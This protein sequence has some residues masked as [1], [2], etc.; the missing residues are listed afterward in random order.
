MAD[1]SLIAKDALRSTVAVPSRGRKQ[2]LEEEEYIGMLEEV[3]ERQYFPHLAKMK[4]QL[5]FLQESE[6]F[7]LHTLRAAYNQLVARDIEEELEESRQ[8]TLT[9]QEFFNRFTSEDNESFK[10]IFAKDVAD[11]RRKLHWLYESL[12]HLAITDGRQATSN[13]KAGMLMLYHIGNKVLTSE[14]RARVD[15]ILDGERV[16]G[17]DRPSQIDTWAFRVRNQ[18][19]FY[20]DLTDS[21]QIS[22]VV[23]SNP[24]NVAGNSL[25][26]ASTASAVST[27][28]GSDVRVRSALPEQAITGRGLLS[29]T[30]V[31]HGDEKKGDFA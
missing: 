2:V 12:D 18:L 25:L 31:A 21:L 29:L 28:S 14:E 9:V 1:R 27:D 5:E 20:P 11:R 24:G 15:A 26:L 22:G 6:R 17:D 23:S 19:M 30:H 3:I 16:V 10:E 7:S 8:N 4:K 13:K